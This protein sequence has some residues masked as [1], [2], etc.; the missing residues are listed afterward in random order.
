MIEAS[1]AFVT[2]RVSHSNG[3]EWTEVTS[4]SRRLFSHSVCEIVA[5]H[6]E[7]LRRNVLEATDGAFLA[8][9]R[10]DSVVEE[11]DATLTTCGCVGSTSK[12]T[13]WTLRAERVGAVGVVKAAL[14]RLTGDVSRVNE[15][16]L[17]QSALRHPSVF[18]DVV[19]ETGITV[20]PA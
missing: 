20:A 10:G 17:T 9:V 7:G 5:I 12:Q 8:V 19:P 2:P 6:T 11:A 4:S 18:S 3:S 13:D 14:T 16:L 1:R 15:A